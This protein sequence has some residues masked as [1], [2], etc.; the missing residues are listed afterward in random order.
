MTKRM[1]LGIV[2]ALL[3][4]PPAARAG[5]KELE[6][7]WVSAAA[8][9]AG[10]PV[11]DDLAKGAEIVFS[12]DK[13]TATLGGVTETGTFTVGRAKKPYTI[14]LKAVSGAKR[15]KGPPAIF[16]VDGDTLRICFALDTKVPPKD[17]TSTA[18]NKHFVVTYKRMK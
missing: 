4:G 14:D 16:E 13:Y 12:G 8:T 11:G 5:D 6:G 17:F 7:T 9:H 2:L 3:A 18:E 10:Q 1:A 15:P